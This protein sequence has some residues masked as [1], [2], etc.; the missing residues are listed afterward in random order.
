M[1]QFTFTHSDLGKWWS[2]DR[3]GE[4]M[5]QPRDYSERNCQEH[6]EESPKL[7]EGEQALASDF[8]ALLQVSIETHVRREAAQEEV[9]ENVV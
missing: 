8:V 1:H 9:P 6:E 3:E 4:A 5:D 2:V 7:F